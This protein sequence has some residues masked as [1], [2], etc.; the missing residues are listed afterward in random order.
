M[1]PFPK[2]TRGADDL[3]YLCYNPIMGKPPKIENL[4]KVLKIKFQL[5]IDIP[6]QKDHKS[7]LKSRYLDVTPPPP[8]HIWECGQKLP[9]RRFFQLPGDFAGHHE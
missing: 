2:W 6:C 8:S 1:A 9:K 3:G 5:K 4:Q 7:R